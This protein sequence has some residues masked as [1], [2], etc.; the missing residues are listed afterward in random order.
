MKYSAIV[1]ASGLTAAYALPAAQPATDL[2]VEK[3]TLGLLHKVLGSLAN[4]GD[5]V[6][7]RIIPSPIVLRRFYTTI[8]IRRQQWH[9]AIVPAIEP[10]VEPAVEPS[11]GPAFWP[12]RLPAIRST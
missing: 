6:A 10:A 12:A 8:V 1:L 4:T 11:I 3:R 5:S 2:A 7:R 9:S